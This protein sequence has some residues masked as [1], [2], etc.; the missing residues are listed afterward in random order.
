MAAF[1]INLKFLYSEI[2]ILC[3]ENQ[4]IFSFINSNNYK[5]ARIEKEIS[6]PL[7]ALMG[8]GY[9]AGTEGCKAKASSTRCRARNYFQT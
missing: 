4:F 1:L 6:S 2:I 7:R 3:L 5:A 8:G 9:A